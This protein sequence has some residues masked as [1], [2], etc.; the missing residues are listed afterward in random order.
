MFALDYYCYSEPP[1]WPGPILQTVHKILDLP[2][3]TS[4]GLYCL[5]SGL[6]DSYNMPLLDCNHPLGEN[7]IAYLS[8]VPKIPD[9][10][11]I[12]LGKYCRFLRTLGES[13]VASTL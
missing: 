10:C 7:M 1:S 12:G 11:P 4:R 9:C 3:F 8:S 13:G 6:N 5:C 2:L